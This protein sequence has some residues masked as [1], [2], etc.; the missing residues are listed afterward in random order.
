MAKV[1]L[2]LQLKKSLEVWGALWAPPPSRDRAHLQLKTNLVITHVKVAFNQSYGH[3]TGAESAQSSTHI[4]SISTLKTLYLSCS[5][6]NRVEAWKTKRKW[7]TGSSYL[8]P[9]FHCNDLQRL[10][11][12]P[13]NVKVSVQRKLIS[14]VLS[15]LVWK[16]RR[17]GRLVFTSGRRHCTKGILLFTVLSQF[18]TEIAIK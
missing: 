16:Q 14:H 5:P 7:G 9:L 6:T 18:L 12:R 13:H 4:T 11:G 1:C 8:L 10:D 2:P 3:S 15:A 17:N